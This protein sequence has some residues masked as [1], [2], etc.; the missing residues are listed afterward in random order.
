MKLDREKLAWAAGFLDGDGN[1]RFHRVRPKERTY[2]YAIIQAGQMGRE[3]LDRLK[4]AVGFGKVYGPYKHKGRGGQYFHYSI[5]AFEETQAVLAML[6]PWLGTQRKAQ[7][8]K[9][10]EAVRA[11]H[12]RPKLKTGPKKGVLNES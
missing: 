9:A 1:I 3:P 8:V 4:S 5:C 12:S 10:F 2:G 11:F 6:W 7:A